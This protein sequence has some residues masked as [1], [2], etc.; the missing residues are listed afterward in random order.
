MNLC[1]HCQIEPATRRLLYVDSEIRNLCA[2]CTLAARAH[3][4]PDLR[5]GDHAIYPGDDD[6]TAEQEVYHC[7]K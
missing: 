3:E 5:V 6:L 4:S 7:L 2:G 1:E